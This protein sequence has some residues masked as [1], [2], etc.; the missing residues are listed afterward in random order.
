MKD[1]FTRREARVI[2][3]PYRW[4]NAM[5]ANATPGAGFRELIPMRPDERIDPEKV[6]RFLAGKLPGAAGTPEIEQF[7]GGHA[8]LTYLVK[9]GTLEYVLRRPP[10]GPVAPKSHDMGREYKVLSVLYQSYPLA[11]RAYLYSEEKDVVGAPF[12]VMERRKGIVIRKEMP[13]GFRNNP[14]LNRRM[15]AM[16]VDGL[17][18]L[19]QVDAKAIGLESL[20]KP[21]GFMERQVSG[22]AGRWEAAKTEE[23]PRFN[24]VHEWMKARIPQKPRA[25]LVHNDYKLDNM[26]VSASDPATCVGVFDWDMCTMGD[27]LADVGTLLGYWIEAGDGPARTAFPTMP[28]TEPGWYTRQEVAEH[29]ARRTGV[30]VADLRFYEIFANWKTAVVIQQIYVRFHRGQTQDVRFKEYGVRAK[31]L[32]D[33]AWDLMRKA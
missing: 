9:Y 33:A 23:V 4:G 17:A 21:E 18:S 14:E 6:G 24:E 2:A 8:N 1:A 28:T 16:I 15:S 10:L 5:L 20:G 26:M 27:P 22:W 29:Y 13:A 7:E 19:H 25:S 11:P 31:G 12:L 30:D 32:I 3:P